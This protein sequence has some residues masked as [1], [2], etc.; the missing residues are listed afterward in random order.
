MSW[1]CAQCGSPNGDTTPT[2]HTCGAVAPQASAQRGGQYAAG[3]PPGAWQQPQAPAGQAGQWGQPQPPGWGAPGPMPAAPAKKS[4]NSKLIGCGIAGCLGVV[5]A[6]G[7]LMGVIFFVAGSSSSS[8]SKPPASGVGSGRLEDLIPS[9][10]GKWKAVSSK[11]LQVEGAVD[12]KLV[13]YRSGSESLEIA[14]AIFPSERVAKGALEGAAD[15]VRKD[16]D[17]V[18]N[19]VNIRDS[20]NNIIGQARQFETNPEVVCYQIDKWMAVVSGPPGDIRDFVR[21]VP[22]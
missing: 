13:K 21:E 14:A 10:V 17:T 18:P 19:R 16:T 4:D 12:A 20:D 3:P 22:Q 9:K 8:P 15:V 7:L 2:C 6:G 5:L 1:F 11:P